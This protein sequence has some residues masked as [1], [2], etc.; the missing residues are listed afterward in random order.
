MSK[1]QS[2]KRYDLEERTFNFA[3]QVRQ[4]ILQIPKNSVSIL[5]NLNFDIV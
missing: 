1:T 4:F 3:Q 5:E 2:S